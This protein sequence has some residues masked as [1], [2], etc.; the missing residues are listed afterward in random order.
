[1]LQNYFFEVQG[2]NSRFSIRAFAKK[3]GLSSS[4]LSEIL[5]GK[6]KI[7]EKKAL[8]IAKKLEFNE[9]EIKSIKR[10]FENSN[11]LE[12]LKATSV[13][14]KEKVLSPETF[15]FMFDRIYFCVLG[16][17][18]SKYK[19]AAEISVKLGLDSHVVENVLDEFVRCGFVYRKNGEFFEAERT[20]FRTSDDF[21]EEGMKKRRLQ[22]NL[23]SRLAIEKSLP[24]EFGYFSTVALDRNKLEEAAP[25]VEDFLKR[26][27]LFLRKPES[28]D[29]FE[30]NIDIFPWSK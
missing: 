22:N 17:L 12:R 6:R 24:G 29:I 30:I 18:R 23:A 19:T 7:S 14:L 8:G 26:L 28:D 2:R 5:R 10:A 9:S 11:S 21:P 27:S 20:V 15:H 16:M 4:A 25:I 1:M 3:L 13:P